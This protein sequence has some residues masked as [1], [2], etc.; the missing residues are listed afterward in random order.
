[1]VTENNLKHSGTVPVIRQ[2]L[3]IITM[4]EPIVSKICLTNHDGKTSIVENG[5]LEQ[6][7]F[8]VIISDKY[9]AF[10]AF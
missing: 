6:C 4:S 8:L 5:V 2:V 10:A 9:F 3:M 1:M 7:E